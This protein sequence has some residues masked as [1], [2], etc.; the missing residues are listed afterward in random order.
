MVPSRNCLTM[1]RS[2]GGTGGLTQPIA[3]IKHHGK[4]D[5]IISNKVILDIPYFAYWKLTEEIPTNTHRQ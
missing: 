5:V 4:G 2:A 3:K 1:L